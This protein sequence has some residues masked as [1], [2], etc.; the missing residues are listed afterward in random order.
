MQAYW[1]VRLAL[2]MRGSSIKTVNIINHRFSDSA[3]QILKKFTIIPE[4]VKRREG[5]YQT[6]FGILTPSFH[7]FER[8][9]KEQIRSSDII[10][11]C[12][13]SRQELFDATILTNPEGR[14]KGRLIVAV[15]SFTPEMRELPE[16]LLLQAVKRHDK[17]HRHFHKHAE[18]GGVIIVDTLE[19]VLAEAGEIITAKIP[20]THLV[21]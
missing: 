2:M 6:K 12:T 9:Q 14:K 11:C 19:G 4:A 20:A 13:P 17:N 8:L 16:G 10:F 3:G 5:W 18:D 21:E 7:E 15:G 1:H